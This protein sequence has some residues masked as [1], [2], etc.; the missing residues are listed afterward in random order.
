VVEFHEAPLSEAR[1]RVCIEGDA[2]IAVD[3]PLF[4]RAVS[5]LL[6]N[7]TRYAVEGSTITVHIGVDAGDRGGHRADARG[8]HVGRLRRG[9]HAHRVCGQPR[10]G[11][12]GSAAK[13]NRRNSP[14]R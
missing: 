14:P 9:P 4:K 8:S 7:A 3:Q 12:R 1:L 5:N 2:E 10:R 13:P 11:A 6:G